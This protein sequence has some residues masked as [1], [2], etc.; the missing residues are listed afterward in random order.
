MS[1]IVNKIKKREEIALSCKNILL[2]KG[3]KNITISE[4]ACCASIS[5]GLFYDYF[6]NKEDIVYEIIRLNIMEYHQEYY[7]NFKENTTTKEKLFYSY[8]FLFSNDEKIQKHKELYREYLSVSLS[9]KDKDLYSFNYE[10]NKFKKNLFKEIIEE[11]INKKEIVP[12]SINLVDSFVAVEKGFLVLS[13]SEGKDFTEEIKKYINT[14][15]SLMEV[16]K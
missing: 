3:I 6:K 1:I 5:K 7:N 8:S 4:L 2:E 12:E 15:C 13:W 10:C 14:I 11:G 16:K 9:I